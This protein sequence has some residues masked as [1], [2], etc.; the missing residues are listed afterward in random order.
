MERTKWDKASTIPWRFHNGSLLTSYYLL[1]SLKFFFRRLCLWDFILFSNWD[2]NSSIPVIDVG[3]LIQTS[4]KYSHM[5]GEMVHQE[6]IRWFISFQN[7]DNRFV[8][9]A[10][11]IIIYNDFFM[12]FYSILKQRKPSNIIKFLLKGN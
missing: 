12:K 8:A 2:N 4:R 9:P 7:F 10:S 6:I 3:L 5:P 11:N 1:G